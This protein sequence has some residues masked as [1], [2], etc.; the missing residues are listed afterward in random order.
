MAHRGSLLVFMVFALAGCSRQ[1]VIG[2]LPKQSEVSPG[3][4]RVEVRGKWVAESP[5][6]GPLMPASNAVSIECS[7]PEMKCHEAVA[8]LFTSVDAVR[9]M[10][11]TLAS[12]L[13]TYDVEEWST[14][15]IRAV[16]RAPAAD[17]TIVISLPVGSVRRD[18]Q[19]SRARGNQTADPN[20]KATWELQ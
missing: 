2:S 17:F 9:S 10:R 1:L 13:G 7:K 8:M 5:L 14:T 12:D 4:D 16:K 19:E 3:G 11:G 6:P 20:N 18:Y 15:A